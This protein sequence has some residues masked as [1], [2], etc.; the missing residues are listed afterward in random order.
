MVYLHVGTCWMEHTHQCRTDGLTHC[1][2]SS[3]TCLGRLHCISHRLF[4]PNAS[5]HSV[6]MYT[7]LHVP[8]WPSSSHSL[9]L[10]IHSPDRFLAPLVAASALHHAAILALT[11]ALRSSFGSSRMAMSSTRSRMCRTHRPSTSSVDGLQP[12]GPYVLYSSGCTDAGLMIQMGTWRF[13]ASSSA[14]SVACVLHDVPT[15]KST[16]AQRIHSCALCAWK[17]L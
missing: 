5:N 2:I 10:S 4:P 8:P 13:E 1:I 11:C 3:T 14:R 7:S 12:G 9:T 15:S 6:Y 17:A 16:S